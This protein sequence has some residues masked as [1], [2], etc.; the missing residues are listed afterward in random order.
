MYTLCV[1][2]TGQPSFRQPLRSIT[3]AVGSQ[4]VF[5]C[6]VVSNPPATVSWTHGQQ[7]LSNGGRIFLN[8]SALVISGVQSSD[9]GYYYCNAQNLFGVNST[10]ASLTIGGKTGIEHTN[11]RK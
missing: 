9:E 4:A 5:Q 1:S 7:N 11:Q 6:L 10:S 8:S 3:A 2:S